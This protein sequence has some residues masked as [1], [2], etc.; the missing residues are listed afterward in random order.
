MIVGHYATALVAH[1]RSQKTPLWIF[2]LC[3]NLADF[4]WLALALVGLESPEP[5]SILDA[6]FRG[7]R[8]DMRFSHD[9][10]PTLMGA[11]AVSLLVYL[12]RRRAAEAL[13]CGA[14][15]IGHL[16]CD[17]LAGYPHHLDGAGTRQIGLGL[18]L[19]A[20]EAAI[21]IEA[22][23]GAA[24]VFFYARSWGAPLRRRSLIGLYAVF[25]LGALAWLPT[26]SR[27]LRS[28]FS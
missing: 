6:S 1:A 22:A 28:L 21:V 19:T 9:A 10:L 24:C 18:Y 4:A 27:S 13:A 7:I 3:A 8:A 12:V 15:V 25:T 26:A 14:L 17:L 23:F 5:A 16:L 2:L 11:A 20:P